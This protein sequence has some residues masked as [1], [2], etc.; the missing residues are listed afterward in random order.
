MDPQAEDSKQ[1]LPSSDSFLAISILAAIK[2]KLNPYF[3][4]RKGYEHRV[5][6]AQTVDEAYFGRLFPTGKFYPEKE[7][8][9]KFCS[10]RKVFEMK[11]SHLRELD[12]ALGNDWDLVFDRTSVGFCLPPV[13]VRLF[14]TKICSSKSPLSYL[15]DVGTTDVVET[16]TTHRLQI[17]F[18]RAAI[19]R[20]TEEYDDETKCYK[21]ADW[22]PKV[23]QLQ[24]KNV[25]L[26]KKR[27][28]IMKKIK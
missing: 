8:S 24:A 20:W 4:G 17:S 9:S 26:C 22:M 3:S 21:E 16:I 15:V 12:T 11:V 18:Y 2:L 14:A 1:V 25:Q 23:R 28:K 6:F 5:A 27:K 10:R 19:S 7:H 13:T